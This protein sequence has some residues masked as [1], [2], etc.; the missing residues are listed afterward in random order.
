MWEAI[1]IVIYLLMVQQ[2]TTKGVHWDV[3]SGYSSLAYCRAAGAELGPFVT[4][5]KGLYQWKCVKYSRR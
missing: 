3:A 2:G 4:A 5:G 1:P